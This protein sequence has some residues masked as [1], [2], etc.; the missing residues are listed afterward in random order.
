MGSIRFKVMNLC[1]MLAWGIL[2]LGRRMLRTYAP[3]G[4][5]LL[6]FSVVWPQTKHQCPPS[7]YTGSRP[8]F[9]VLW[10]LDLCSLV[11]VTELKGMALSSIRGWSHGG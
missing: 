2:F 7:I 5:C 11:T 10:K 9:I 4:D 8:D 3:P 1:M 6:L